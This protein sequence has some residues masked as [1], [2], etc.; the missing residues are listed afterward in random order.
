[1]EE[2]TMKKFLALIL[3]ALLTFGCVSMAVAE[4]AKRPLEGVTLSYWY[5]MWA[6]ESQFVGTGDMSDLTFYASLEEQLGCTIEWILPPVDDAA[7]KAA[8]NVL[9][10]SSDLPDIVTHP[11]YTYYPSGNDAAIADGVYIDLKPLL[12][13]YAPNYWKLLQEDEEMMKQVTTDEGHIWCLYMIDSFAQ[14]SYSG[15]VWRKDFIEK[16]DGKLPETIDE[17]Y[18]LLTK[19]K[20]ELGL[21]YPIY[22]D[23]V[24][25][26]PFAWGVK[27]DFFLDEEGKVQYGPIQEGW[28]EYLKTMHK[29][30]AEGL[31]AEDYQ[32]PE[33]N[34]QSWVNGKIGVAYQGFNNMTEIVPLAQAANVEGFAMIASEYPTLEAGQQV[35]FKAVHAYRA[36]QNCTAITADC[37]NPEAALMFLD[38]K[39][40]EE[41]ILASNYGV[42]G[43]HWDMVDGKPVYRDE[44]A[45]PTEP[46]MTLGIY[47]YKYALGKGPY[48]R[49]MDRNWFT[50]LPEAI[51]AMYLWDGSTDGGTGDIADPFISMPVEE[52]EEY[53]AIVNDAQTY[54]NEA[55]VKFITGE[56][57]IET[58]WDEYVAT[59]EGMD[60]ET[61][62]EIKQGAVDRYNAR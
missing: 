9:L 46:G 21:Q 51:D 57:D 48:Y 47:L 60:I 53:S 54:A 5:P 61:A 36:Q 33:D 58:K 43:E 56:W 10:A 4:D 41:N 7:A 30:Y 62:I 45:Y 40:T 19:F 34:K 3:A 13:E 15:P 24:N 35:R 1:M 12:P 14:P 2:K 11:Y 6:W 27:N 50:H 22:D 39:F 31:L 32:A 29:W 38:A 49:I 37:E 16:V 42:E 26:L 23:G 55:R 28:K 18:E 44:M 25:Y 59:I 17:M 8:L 52:G 20:N